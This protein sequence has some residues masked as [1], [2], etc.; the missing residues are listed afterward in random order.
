[1]YIH[2]TVTVGHTG[3]ADLKCSA[4]F[5][6]ML[7]VR[8]SNDKFDI[9]LMVMIETHWDTRGCFDSLITEKTFFLARRFNTQRHHQLVNCNGNKLDSYWYRGLGEGLRFELCRELDSLLDEPGN[10]SLLPALPQKNQ[11][12]SKRFLLL[13]ET[14]KIL[15]RSKKGL[16][17]SQFSERFKRRFWFY[18]HG[19]DK[20]GKWQNTPLHHT[21]FNLGFF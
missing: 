12:L 21:G 15:G 13:I 6:V 18:P 1:M 5:G 9:T 4:H 14:E 17:Q 10:D 16:V 7:K 19:Y 3:L 2:K 20:I 11:T 8:D